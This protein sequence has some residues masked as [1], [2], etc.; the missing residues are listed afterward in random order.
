MKFFIA[1]C[2][3]A[4]AAAAPP[5]DNIQVVK[6]D[7]DNIGIGNYRFLLE[8]SDGSKQEQYGE[9][10]NEGQVGQAVQVRGS[11]SW[12]APDG[13]KYTVNYVADENGYR[14]TIDKE[15]RQYRLSSQ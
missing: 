9:L 2:L 15:E 1:L 3:L 14:S 8:Q 13:Y 6:Y 7:N 10:K 12:I 11:Y 4:V 5:Y